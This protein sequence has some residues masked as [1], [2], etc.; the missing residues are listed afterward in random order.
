MKDIDE[1]RL[2]VGMT[3]G[4]GQGKA[5]PATTQEGKS[6]TGCADADGMS[7][8]VVYCVWLCVTVCVTV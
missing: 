1:R 2:A 6:C 7:C 8:A 3:T 5:S 4:K